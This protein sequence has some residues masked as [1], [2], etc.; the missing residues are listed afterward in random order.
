M[1]REELIQRSP[2]P[3]DKRSSLVSLT[4]KARARVPK[5]KQALLQA[6]RE[7]LAGLSQQDKATLRELLQGV[8]SNVER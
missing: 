8:V 7:V 5:A 6:E 4:H 3:H 1:E 2:H